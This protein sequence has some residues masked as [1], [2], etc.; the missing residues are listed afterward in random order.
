MLQKSPRGKESG[1]DGAGVRVEG[2]RRSG[3]GMGFAGTKEGVLF[4]SK[5]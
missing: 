1:K 3:G 2:P 5:K 4:R